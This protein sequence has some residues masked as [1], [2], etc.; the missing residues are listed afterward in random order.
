MKKLLLFILCISPICS[1]GEE[2]LNPHFDA[3]LKLYAARDYA[4]ALDAFNAG[5]KD[6]PSSQIGHYLQCKA[7]IHLKKYD[8]A[9]TSYNLARSSI[10]DKKP[11]KGEHLSKSNREILA[12]IALIRTLDEDTD[13][14][15]TIKSFA[16][17]YIKR[18]PSSKV[19]YTLLGSY[20]FQSDNSEALERAATQLERLSP[21][22][23]AAYAFRAMACLHN[24]DFAGA[25][26][27]LAEALRLDPENILALGIQKE[28]PLDNVATQG[29][30]A[31][32]NS[33]W[34]TWVIGI[35]ILGFLILVL[36]EKSP[37]MSKLILLAMLLCPPGLSYIVARGI[38]YKVDSQM[39]ESLI[40]KNSTPEYIEKLSQ[41]RL[42]T[43]CAIP[44]FRD[45]AADICSEIDNLNWMKLAGIYIAL[46][47]I[48]LLGAIQLAGILSGKS[49]AAL[50]LL[51]SPGLYVTVGLTSI[52][53]I[54][55]AALLIA[56]IWYGESALIGR[57]H[58]GIM[59]ALGI[60][61]LVGVVTMI[62]ACF[63]ALG[64]ASS[65]EFAKKLTEKE[66]PEL[67]KYIK[68]LS[69]RLKAAPPQH[70][71]VG[72]N[73]NFYVTEANV[74]CLDG[75]LTGRTLYLSLPLCRILSKNELT[76]IIGH[77]LGHFVG[78]D[79]KF[80]LRFYPI[81]RGAGEALVNLEQGDSQS[82]GVTL[83]VLPVR[84]IL[85]YF[86]QAFATAENGISR[87]RE[88]AAD[89][90]GAELG[91]ATDIA[92]AL[93]KIHAFA[94]AWSG[95]EDL[96]REQLSKGRSIINI[97]SL[98]AQYIGDNSNKDVLKDLDN[99]KITHPTDSHPLL[100]DRLSSLSVSMDSVS[101]LALNTKLPEPAITLVHNY[102]EVEKEL[103][104][105]RQVMM[106]KVGEVTLPKEDAANETTQKEN[107]SVPSKPATLKDKF[108]KNTKSKKE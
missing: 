29:P 80:S 96:M 7:Q 74:I 79:T 35:V 61:A 89:R 67:W 97:S 43:L 105:L 65:R 36:R 27:A 99:M 60:G 57:V 52:F 22:D 53:V 81:Y 26:T 20:G 14:L 46:A 1:W 68:E 102:E 78:Q 64:K 40:D 15:E 95:I 94:P 59:A 13:N 3:G 21:N 88:L 93:V 103:S 55:N 63:S 75:T 34:K 17:E 2:S 73:P 86:L 51:F 33:N 98:Y 84:L 69:G 4:A 19:A 9:I 72:L 56:S 91:N 41:A 18:D 101:D 62:K 8:E 38:E 42:S 108:A 106:V 58:I 45:K 92:S 85:G 47:A 44:E 32:S 50:L 12:A 104:E 16:N 11:K 25:K 76:G 54:V 24:K 71:V 31:N 70:I 28:I 6:E 39:R 82:A 100:S 23:S 5:L 49:R 10:V 66:A 90:I 83:A 77:E 87:D 30:V 107:N 37:I 48:S